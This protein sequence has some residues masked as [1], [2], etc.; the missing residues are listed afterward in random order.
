MQND[1]PIA[2]LIVAKSNGFSKDGRGRVLQL[3][4]DRHQQRLLGVHVGAWRLH[5]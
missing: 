4:R 5:C 1:S 3:Q 2:S